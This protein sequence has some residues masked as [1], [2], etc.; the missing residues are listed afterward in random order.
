MQT[1]AGTY[2]IDVDLVHDLADRV[3]V[4]ESAQLAGA[5][6]VS[7]VNSGRARPGKHGQTVLTAIGG[8]NDNGLALNAPSSAVVSYNLVQIS[9][10]ELAILSNIDFS[11]GRSNALSPNARQV[12]EHVNAIQNAGGTDSFAPIVAALMELPDDPSLNA[13]YKKLIPESLG[14]LTTETA[15]TSVG[16]HDALHSCRQQD[17]DHRFVRE[18]ECRWMRV[19]GFTR[20][21]DETSHNPGYQL[22]AFSIAGGVQQEIATNTHLGFG[23]SFQNS[24]LDS[25]LSD[26]DGNQIEGGIIIKRRYD[27]TMISGSVSAGYGWYDSERVVGLPVPGVSASSD[28]DIFF[29]SIHGRVSHDFELGMNKYIR[30]LV[31]LGATQVHRKGFNEKGAGGANLKVD[32]DDET[33]VTLQPAIEFGGEFRRDSGTLVRPYARIGVTHYLTDNKHRVTATMQGAPGNV[34]PFTI[35]TK[36]DRTY[37]DFSLGV[38]VIKKKGASLRLG[39]TGQF[40]DNSSSHAAGIKLSIPF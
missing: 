23:L 4:S 34:A 33:L 36:S 15:T 9:S 35:E 39:Y 10:N 37:A 32:S 28:Q 14:S 21:Q 8:I 3:D 7:V 27:A 16:F 13:A 30:P 17:G 24:D 19:D 38:D 25:S 18:G 22:D 31:D 20:D 11:P 6:S 12:A 26:S 29:G 2:A 5:L 40:S 1:A